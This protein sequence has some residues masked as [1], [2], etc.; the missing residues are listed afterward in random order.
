MVFLNHVA[1]IDIAVSIVTISTSKWQKYGNIGIDELK[2]TDDESGKILVEMLGEKFLISKYRLVPDDMEAIRK[3]VLE[4]LE[5]SDA[6]ITTGGTGITPKDVTIE[7]VDPLI[8][9]KLDGFGEIFRMLSYQQVRSAAILSRAMAGVRDGKAIFCL[10]GSP[11]AVKLG[12]ELILDSL[13]HV[14]SH[15]RGLK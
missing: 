2:K 1:D 15:A 14:I 4:C 13:K 5:V 6:V 10:P 12:A 11:K 9:K 3:A 8:K 7:A